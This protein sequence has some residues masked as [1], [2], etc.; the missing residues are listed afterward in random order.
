MNDL[1]N[2]KKFVWGL[3][4]VFTIVWLYVLG[5]RTLVPPDEGRYAEMAREMWANGDWITTRLNGIKYFEKP[6][7]QTWMNALSFGLFGYGE[8]QARLWTGLCG[9]GGVIFTGYAASRVFSARAGFYAA[10]VLG[11]SLFWVASGQ[12]DSLDMSLSGM[13]TIALCGLVIAQHDGATPSE[14]RNWM[15]V[16]WAGM[17]LAVLAK[18]LIGLVL[19]GAVL[20]LYSALSRD[21]AIWKRLHLGKGLLLFFAIATP[22]FVLVALKNPEQPHFFFIHEHWE[23][24]FLKTH[25]REGAWYY[26]LVML[27]PGLMPWL[28]VAPQALLN[29]VKREQQAVFQPKL[30]L[31][32]WVVFITFFFSYSSSKLPGYI[33]PV[34]P[35]MAMLSAVYLENASRLQR[36]IAAGLLIVVGVAGLAAVPQMAH[37]AVRHPEERVLLEAYQPWVLTAAIIATA[38]GALALLHARQ[39][40]RDLSVLTLA[41]AGFL[42]VQ[43]ILTGFEP[44]GKMRAGKALAMKMLPELKPDTKIYSVATYEQSMTFYLKR[45][46]ILV[47]YWDEFTFG[48]RQQPELSIPTLDGFVAQWQQHSADNV[49]ALAIISNEAYETLKAKGVTMRVVAEDTRRLVITNL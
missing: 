30:M 48:L 25:H 26:F 6:P 42:S 22:W 18:G 17:A 44:Y 24:F 16:C 45:T 49:K 35:A 12:I 37:M 9:L 8:W 5:I 43:L 28:G 19:P 10:L 20:V 34:F 15:L 38:G 27:I 7:L 39:L 47:D 3:L 36:T 46:V 21:L 14:Q 4:A 41:I 23:R 32:I 2:S 13:M 40:R 29:G 33:L 11:S 1:Y 31:V